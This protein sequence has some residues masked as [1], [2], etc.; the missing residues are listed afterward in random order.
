LAGCDGPAS[1]VRSNGGIGWPGQP[2]PV[3]IVLADAEL[4]G[5]LP[6]EGGQVVAGRNGLV[7]AFRLG[8]HARW[9]LLVTRPAGADPAPFGQPGPAVPAA[10]LQSLLDEA[11]SGMGI[12]SLAWSARVRVQHRVATRFRRGRLYL[13]GDAAHAY[14]PATGQGLNAAIQDALNLG[15]KLAFGASCPDSDALLDSYEWERR[16]VARQVLAMTHLVFW[17]EAG[18]GPA[19]RRDGHVCRAEHPAAPTDRPLGRACA[20][21]P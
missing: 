13:A 14:S 9:R 15:W 3:E 10:E 8:E 1:I 19:A 5:D 16:P 20:P 12:E 2:Y 7:F 17:A 4:A 6:D 18:T 11:H 21:R